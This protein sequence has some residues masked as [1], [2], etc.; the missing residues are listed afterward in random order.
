MMSQQLIVRN[1]A[2]HTAVGPFAA[3]IRDAQSAEIQ[4]MAAWLRQ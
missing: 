2:M 1:L 3:N 4:M